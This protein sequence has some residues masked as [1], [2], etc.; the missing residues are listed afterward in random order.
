MRLPAQQPNGL[1]Q[2]R[3]VIKSKRAI[4]V[5]PKPTTMLM[6]SPEG[7]S[8]GCAVFR[9]PLMLSVYFSW[10]LVANVAVSSLYVPF[11]DSVTANSSEPSALEGKTFTVA[12]S[13]NPAE[14]QE[15][16]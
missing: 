13:V 5:S 9:S 10:C 7:N 14:R 2:L 16:H 6:L 8:F 4:Q 12:L 1:G 11:T 3:E 15:V